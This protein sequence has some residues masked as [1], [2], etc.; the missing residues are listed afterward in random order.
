MTDTKLA[1]QLAVTEK[2]LAD[3]QR[4]TA[5]L[6]ATRDSEQAAFRDAET[7]RLAGQ[8]EAANE[9]ASLAS[10]AKRDALFNEA[11]ALTSLQPRT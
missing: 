3:E 8:M 9:Q 2:A 11:A 4:K 5:D 7:K 6:V 10:A 1:E